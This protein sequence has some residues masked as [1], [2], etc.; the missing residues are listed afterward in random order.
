MVHGCPHP[1]PNGEGDAAATAA[2]REGVMADP[3][4]AHAPAEA[5]AGRMMDVLDG[6][7]ATPMT[8][9]GHQV[10]SFG[11]M[12]SLAPEALLTTLSSSSLCDRTPWTHP[13]RLTRW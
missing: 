13:D 7:G 3:A 6:A 10:G 8:S 1:W 9:I 11:T 4:F 2:V 12:A 5:F